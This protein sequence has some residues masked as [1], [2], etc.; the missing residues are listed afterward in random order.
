MQGIRTFACV[1]SLLV[2][3]ADAH[4]QV[5]RLEADAALKHSAVQ[6]ALKAA[7]LMNGPDPIA[8]TGWLSRFAIG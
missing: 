5:T 1:L 6:L 8:W 7:E 3:R 2:A 4:A